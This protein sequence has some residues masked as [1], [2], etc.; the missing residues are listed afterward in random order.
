MRASRSTHASAAQRSSIQ[1][2]SKRVGHVDCRSKAFLDRLL[3]SVR[4]NFETI[5]RRLHN[6]GTP[7]PTIDVPISHELSVADADKLVADGHAELVTDEMR[8][9]F[10]DRGHIR[11]F[12]VVEYKP[13]GPR[14][15]AIGHPADVNDYLRQ[16][17]ARSGTNVAMQPPMTKVSDY[18][19]VFESHNKTEP[20]FGMTFDGT[21]AFWQ[22]QLDKPAWALQRY[23]DESGR[24]FQFKKL[25]MGHVD[26][27][28]LMQIIV[29]NVAGHKSVVHGNYATKA[30]I[31]HVWVD[32][33]R[34]AGTK[35]QLTAAGKQVLEVA[36]FFNFTMKETEAIIQSIYDF[37]GMLFQHHATKSGL[38]VV[39]L[40]DK[41]RDKI[42]GTVIS[43]QMPAGNVERLLGQL[44]FGSAVCQVPLATFWRAMKYARFICNQL[45]RGI[46]DTNT[47][48]EVPPQAQRDMSIWAAKVTENSSVFVAR[49]GPK[50][51]ILFVDATLTGFGIVLVMHDNQLLINGGKFDSDPTK[52]IADREAEAAAI[53]F[54][55]FERHLKM[56]DNVQLYIDNTVAEYSFK[57]GNAKS[58]HVAA[59]VAEVLNKTRGWNLTVVPLRVTSEDNPADEPSRD[60]PVSME[61]VRAAVQRA[62]ASQATGNRS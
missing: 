5:W 4:D 16:R 13:D 42:R 17:D 59:A 30:P 56:L 6:P 33:F 31:C 23:R 7:P 25:L 12:S 27:V 41:T 9:Q 48:V 47:I 51:G 24:L 60:A 37:I 44:I 11:C 35:Q 38:G 36:K 1:L 50:Q 3:P 20:T 21:V 19:N 32:G 29:A 46:V 22:V 45:N 53:A 52:I 55:C 2:H 15:R 34:Y 62:W 61:K 57:K 39:R 28:K 14:R 18:V 40:S 49:T 54:R 43:N 58:E 26:S 8:K 10:P